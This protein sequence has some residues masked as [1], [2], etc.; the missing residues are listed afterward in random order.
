[1]SVLRSS[2]P[3]KLAIVRPVTSEH[4]IGNKTTL[5]STCA[6]SRIAWR[7][8]KVLALC[9]FNGGGQAWILGTLRRITFRN[10]PQE[11]KDGQVARQPKETGHGTPESLHP[12]SGAID[13]II[14]LVHT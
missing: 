6:Y 3:V 5:H 12:S 10:S 14:E 1:M 2:A 4:G 9:L 11:Q 8:V 7:S 13:V